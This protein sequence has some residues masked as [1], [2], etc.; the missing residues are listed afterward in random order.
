MI[1]IV[2]LSYGKD[3]TVMLDKMIRE[4]RNITHIIFCDTL[5]EFPKLHEYRK[6]YNEYLKSRYGL[7]AV[8]L[9]PS[10]TFEDWIFGRITK[11][12]RKG[13]IRGLPLITIPCYWKRE[14]KT[15][16]AEKWV[17]ERYPK[18]EVTFHLGFAKGEDRSVKD[19]KYFKYKYP[20]K[21]YGMTE[22]DC[23]IY[24]KEYEMENELYREFTRLGCMNCPYQ[25]EES[26]KTIYDNH[27][28]V[29]EWVKM[30]EAE[31]QRLEDTGEKIVNKHFFMGY[32]TTKDMEYKFK[33]TAD[34]LFDLSS[35]PLKNCFCFRG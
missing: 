4:G 34:G 15:V 10:T 6:T 16:P 12:D 26:W 30:I 25:P 29:W 28:R 1:N 7:D 9:K 35:E 13:Q 3:S 21:E 31:L 32:L 22:M 23:L 8:T 11:G 20:L 5:W 19:T 2:M 17:K 14:S 18:Q 27:P 24:L 33:H